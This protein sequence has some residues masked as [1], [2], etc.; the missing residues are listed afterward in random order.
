MFALT[1]WSH[2]RRR[3]S[4]E[5]SG[6]STQKEVHF[7]L[8]R[9]RAWERLPVCALNIFEIHHKKLIG[10]QR[11]GKGLAKFCLVAHKSTFLKS[12]NI[13]VWI[14]LIQLYPPF[15]SRG[16]CEFHLDGSVDF[17]EG[18]WPLFYC[19]LLLLS[20]PTP[21]LTNHFKKFTKYLPTCFSILKYLKLASCASCLTP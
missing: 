2:W 4:T 6:G 9:L 19:P 11:V 18:S 13:N 8:Q 15:S 10:T 12:P 7:V 3:L 5:V 1:K 17:F 14:C 16:C 21:M 20:A